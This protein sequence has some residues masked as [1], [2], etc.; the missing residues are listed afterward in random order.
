MIAIDTNLLVRIL[1]DDPGQPRQ[2]TAARE[3]AAG[4]LRTQVVYTQTTMSAYTHLYVIKYPSPN[5]PLNHSSTQN[6]R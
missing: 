3:I 5:E 1:V 2:V 4:V 6:N